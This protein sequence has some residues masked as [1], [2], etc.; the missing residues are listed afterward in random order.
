MLQLSL[1]FTIAIFTFRNHRNLY[2]S[3]IFITLFLGAQRCLPRLDWICSGID[4][5]L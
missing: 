4:G 5:G 2:A 1:Q 3:D